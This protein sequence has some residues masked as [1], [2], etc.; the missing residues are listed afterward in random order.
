MWLSIGVIMQSHASEDHA[1]IKAIKSVNVY[2]IVF[3]LN[4]Q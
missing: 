1:K 4:Y 3:I 2:F